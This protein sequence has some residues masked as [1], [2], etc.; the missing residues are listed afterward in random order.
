MAENTEAKKES[1]EKGE[2]EV[3]EVVAEDTVIVVEETVTPETEAESR[4]KTTQNLAALAIIF[5][6]L[7]AGSLFVDFFQLIGKQGFSQHALQDASV[8]ESAGKTWVAYTDPKIEVKVLNDAACEA[9]NADQAL[10]SLRRALPTIDATQVD[11]ET[12]EGQ[13]MVKDSAVK[14]LP[15]FF[16]GPTI[17]KASLFAQAQPL[18]KKMPDGWYSLDT[19]QLGIPP[20]K[21]L[22]LPSTDGAA[23]SL[24]NP[25]AKVKV[26]EYSDWQCPYCRAMHPAIKQMLQDYKD[27]VY[28][29]YK[30]F[31]LTSIHPQAMNAALAV[32]CANEQGAGKWF[33][34]GDSLFAKQDEWTKTPGT[35]KFKDYARALKL[36]G[37]KFDQCLDTKKYAPQ[38]AADQKEGESFGI[39]GTPGTFVGSQF[40]GG[41]VAAPDFKKLIDGELAK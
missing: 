25:D 38:I 30:Q 6:G 5:A 39:S 3:V 32:S 15:A 24:G 10:V 16:F 20:G 31:P 40:L 23:L 2:P 34:Y 14:S 12:P 11:V 9:C 4:R 21:F 18:F 13:Q 8:V 33:E 35:Q 27:Q 22:T 19:V 1:G 37:A 41:Y 26:V 36:D 28:Y 29:V 17:E 7:F